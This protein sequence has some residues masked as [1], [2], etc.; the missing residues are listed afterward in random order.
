MSLHLQMRKLFLLLTCLFFLKDEI[1]SQDAP[2]GFPQ[3]FLGHWKGKI[4]WVVAGKPT[5]QFSMQLKVRERG[6]SA[7]LYEW[8]ISYGDS[9][10]DERPYLLKPA[11]ISKGHWVI[12]EANGIVLDEYVFDN[13]LQGSF[14]VTNNTIINNYCVENGKMKVEF[15][16]IKLGDKNT[17]GKGT[18][19]APF[20]DNY[21]IAGYRHGILEKVN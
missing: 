2:P 12:D 14:T 13:C 9:A 15:F 4:S 11:D 7:G 19:A 18:E 3:R 21:R 17:T 10:S 5:R 16:T 1:K 20:V 8:H 6:D